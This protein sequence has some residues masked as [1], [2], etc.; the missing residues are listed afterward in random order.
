MGRAGGST[1]SSDAPLR[2]LKTL[3][4]GAPTLLVLSC[5]LGNNSEIATRT[6]SSGSLRESE[7]RMVQSADTH[8]FCQLETHS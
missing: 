8:P 1:F 2:M 3:V 6:G 4:D 7:Q 5:I